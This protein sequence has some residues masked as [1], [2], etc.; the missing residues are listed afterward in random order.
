MSTAG[1]EKKMNA[2]MTP[3]KFALEHVGDFKRYE[4]AGG[5]IG[6]CFV[7]LDGSLTSAISM[8]HC[9]AAPWCHSKDLGFV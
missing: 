6:I 7:V 5:F 9:Y 8:Q 4:R 1:N 2:P 3:A